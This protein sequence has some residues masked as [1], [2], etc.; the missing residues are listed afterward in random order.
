M[1]ITELLDGFENKKPRKANSYS[2][3]DEFEV[4]TTNDEAELLKRLS[5]PVRISALS[6]QDQFKVQAMI[7]KSLVTK[8]GFENPTVVANEKT[9]K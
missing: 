4:W 7:R 3:L 2:I 9:Q 8:V 1:K 6:E 5:K